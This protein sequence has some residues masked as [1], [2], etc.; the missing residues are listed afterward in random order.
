MLF[1]AMHSESRKP[2]LIF[3]RLNT[4]EPGVILKAIFML[5]HCTVR[6]KNVVSIK[7][8]VVIIA[9]INPSKLLN[10]NITGSDTGAFRYV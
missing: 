3:K 1:L 8:G 2:N 6:L 5:H 7:E 10:K 4:G 9:K